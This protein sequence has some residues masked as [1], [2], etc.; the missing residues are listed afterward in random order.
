M[1][2]LRQ[3]VVCWLWWGLRWG[4]WDAVLGLMFVGCLLFVFVGVMLLIVL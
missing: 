1:A 4:G 2:V 3:F